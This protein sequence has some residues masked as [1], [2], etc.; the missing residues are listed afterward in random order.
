LSRKP[1]RRLAA[2][3]ETILAGHDNVVPLRVL[4]QIFGN[5]VTEDLPARRPCRR[6]RYKGAALSKQQRKAEKT[7]DRVARFTRLWKRAQRPLYAILGICPN[8]FPIDREN[9]NSAR[10]CRCLGD[11]P[12]AKKCRLRKG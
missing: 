11:R 3:V 10:L 1:L 2:L 7:K 8:S 5:V 4:S 9:P 6:F 12:G